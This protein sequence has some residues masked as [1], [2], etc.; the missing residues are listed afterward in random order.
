MPPV[1]RTTGFTAAAAALQFYERRQEVIANNL[2]NASTTGFKA[3]LQ[4]ARQAE[5]AVMTANTT[6]D[7]TAGTITPTGNPLDVA[8][9]GDGMLVVQTPDGERLLRGGPL[10]L[11]AERRLVTGDGF[12]VLGERGPI[13]LPPGEIG[14]AS[15]GVITVTTPML[16]AVGSE[17]TTGGRIAGRP[18]DVLRVERMPD[19]ELVHAGRGLY[20]P[21]T[22][23]TLMAPD[24][25]GVRQ[26]ALEESNVQ[27]MTTLVEMLETVRAYGDVQK[28]LSVLDEVRGIA[29]SQVGKPV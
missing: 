13:V 10:R 21:G 19:G 12:P 14:I 6:T 26:G 3:T 27:P 28:S 22:E 1:L 5:D 4:Y 16:D 25:R 8:L 24:A 11:D 29:A 17:R 15:D 7:R 20:L 18:I 23:R 2:A 9:Q